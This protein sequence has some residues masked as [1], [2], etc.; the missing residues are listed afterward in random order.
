MFRVK[1]RTFLKD[2]CHA[3]TRYYI[4]SSPRTQPSPCA[5]TGPSRTACMNPI[6]TILNEDLRRSRKRHGAV[7][8]ATV[9]HCAFNLVRTLTGK[10]SL[11]HRRK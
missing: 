1:A 11:K 4:S 7:N 3:D 5:V 9:C 2:H 10:R 8:M 6:D